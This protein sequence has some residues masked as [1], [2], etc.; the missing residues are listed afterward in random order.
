MNKVTSN[1][2]F[3]IQRLKQVRRILG[4]EITT[5]LITAFVTS[6]LDYCNSVLASLPKS[7]I[8]RFNGSRMSQPVS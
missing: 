2:F 1:C 5:S 7:T 6:R 3:Q 8:A 4:A